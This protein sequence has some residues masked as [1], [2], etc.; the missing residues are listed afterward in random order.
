M[1]GNKP[2]FN[3]ELMD[4]R[5]EVYLPMGL[6]AEEVARRYKVTREDQDQFAYHSHR[7]ALAAIRD[8]KFKEEI[9]PVG[10]V[11]FQQ[12]D[13]GPPLRKRSSSTRTTVRVPTRRSRRWRSSSPP[14]TRRGP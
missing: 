2:S 13:G 4:N 6:T 7:K 11:L 8:G 14:S 12:K 3:P 10:T 9:V 1:G 5:P